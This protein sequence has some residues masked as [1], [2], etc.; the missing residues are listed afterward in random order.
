MVLGSQDHGRHWTLVGSFFII[1]SFSP[2]QEFQIPI[3]VP[4]ASI[5]KGIAQDWVSSGPRNVEQHIQPQRL[6]IGPSMNMRPSGP[7][8]VNPPIVTINSWTCILSFFGLYVGK[9]VSS[10]TQSCLT[11]C[12]PMDCRTPGFPVHHQFL[13]FTQTHT[14]WVGDAIQPSHPPS[15]P[16]P[17]ALSL[18]QHQGLLQWVSSSHQVAKVLEFQ[19]H[20]CPSNEYSGL[21]SFRMDWLDLLAVQGTLKSLLQ[22]HSSKALLLRCLAFFIAQLSHPYMITGKTV[23][24]TRQTFVGKVV[25]A[26]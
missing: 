26:F 16:S 18:P 2:S 13:E 4:C 20:I 25:S 7:T 1:F 23:S 22:H 12:N 10:V 8:R 15:L 6:L 11:L 24:L 9:T 14:H 21:I 3:G 5:K 17:S 19:L